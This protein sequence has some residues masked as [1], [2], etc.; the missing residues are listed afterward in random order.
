MAAIQEVNWQEKLQLNPATKF[1]VKK[2]KIAEP[3]Y[4]DKTAKKSLVRDIWQ[5]EDLQFAI[6][7]GFDHLEKPNR[8]LGI[9][10]SSRWTIWP[11]SRFVITTDKLK[12]G[13]LKISGRNV[14]GEQVIKVYGEDELLLEEPVL[15]TAISQS[16]TFTV[17]V[18]LQPGSNYFSLKT[19]KYLIDGANR[20]LALLIESVVFEEDG[21][22]NN[23]EGKVKQDILMSDRLNGWGWFPSEFYGDKPVRWLEK[24]GGIIAEVAVENAAK[25]EVN[26]LAAVEAEFLGDLTVKI[27]DRSLEGEVKQQS[28]S[29]WVFEGIIPTGTVVRGETCLIMLETSGVRQLGENDPRFASLLVEKVVLKPFEEEKVF[30][31]KAILMDDD[32]QGYGWFPAEFFQE[33]WVRWMEKIGTIITE[34][35]VVKALEIQIE[36]L[37]ATKPDFVEGMTVKVGDILVENATIKRESEISWTFNGV[38]PAGAIAPD[39][40]CVIYIESPGVKKLSPKDSR[41]AS[42][43]V[44]QVILKDVD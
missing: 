27:N 28:D 7:R 20:H 11:E 32:L 8:D 2:P 29:L 10:T 14:C 26:V 43:L 15:N 36:G 42:L 33:N 16:N 40:P 18:E 41:T 17:P 37:L 21:A 31:N 25:I 24:K 3:I 30:K 6:L 44:K 39:R 22:S 12:K 19:E 23:C 1:G 9:S 5:G 35:P 34:I 38:I 13:Q 4:I